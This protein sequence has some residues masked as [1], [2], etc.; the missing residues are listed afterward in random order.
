MIAIDPNLWLFS[1]LALG[2]GWKPIVLL[3]AGV[4][5][6][7]ALWLRVWSMPILLPVRTTADPGFLFLAYLLLCAG[8]ILSVARLLDLEN[9]GL[10]DLTRLSGQQIPRVLAMVLVGTSWPYVFASAVCIGLHSR[11]DGDPWS[12]IVAAFLLGAAVGAALLTYWALPAAMVTDSAFLMPLLGILAFVALNFLQMV[13]WIQQRQLDH[14]RAR[15]T[16]ATIALV[17]PVAWWLACRR[18]R[19]P[20]VLARRGAT[21]LFDTVSRV[22]PRVGPPEFLRHLR[23]TV[24]SGGTLATLLLAPTIV[25]VVA[26]RTSDVR[27]DLRNVALMAMPF[28]VALIGPFAMLSSARRAI[29]T[30]TIDLARITPQRAVSVV[31]GWWAGVSMP[32][33]IA[34]VLALGALAVVGVLRL[35]PAGARAGAVVFVSVLALIAFAFPAIALAERLHRRRT[36]AYLVTLLFMALPVL[37]YATTREEVPTSLI[38]SIRGNPRPSLADFESFRFAEDNRMRALPDLEWRHGAWD[39]THYMW[40]RQTVAPQFIP[41]LVFLLTILPLAAAAGRFERA[42]GPSFAGGAVLGA[43]AAVALILGALPLMAMPRSAAALLVVLAV[44]R[45]SCAPVG[46]AGAARSRRQ[47]ARR[48]R[49]RSACSDTNSGGR[50][51]SS[52]PRCARRYSFWCC[53]SSGSYRIWWTLERAPRRPD[54][55]SICRPR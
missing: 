14:P 28:F 49:S 8:P 34:T 45:F 44:S 40:R 7:A 13:T 46:S 27:S 11:I 23:C 4:A 21:D 26:L 9:G 6:G 54:A 42:H 3:V 17:L 38:M 35:P 30:R 37:M 20:R 18:L 31:V 33:W 41:L 1:R 10:L 29:E 55:G 25:I 2:R 5:V 22:I 24:L 48:P 52:R 12:A 39:G 36:G 15:A 50:N 16:M 53:G 32:Y 43:V 19:R 51:P 47:R